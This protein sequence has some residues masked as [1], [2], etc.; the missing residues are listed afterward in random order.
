[1]GHSGAAAYV[2]H[3]SYVCSLDLKNCNYKEIMLC[4]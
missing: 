1:M 2:L 3:Y 4:D